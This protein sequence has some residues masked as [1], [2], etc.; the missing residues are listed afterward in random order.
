MRTYHAVVPPSAMISA[1]LTNELSSD[2]RNSATAAISSGRPGVPRMIFSVIGP[3]HA[4]SSNDARVAGVDKAPGEMELAR[5]PYLR[6][7]IASWRV[8]AMT[9]PL[10]AQ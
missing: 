6:P 3:P 5:I 8:I 2:A 9:P 4:G 1:A 10:A 7:S